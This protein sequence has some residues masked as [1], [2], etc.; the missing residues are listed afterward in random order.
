MRVGGVDGVPGGWVVCVLSGS[1]RT[2]RVSWSVVPDA[3]AVLELG[4]GCDAVGVDIPLVLPAGGV[5]RPAEVEAAARLGTARSSLFPTPPEQVL[6]A[7]SYP[8]ACA[9]AQRV[10]GR[11]ISVQTW[12]IV[13]KIRE[14]QRVE[15][16]G[17]VVEAH[18]ELSF[19]TM[20][21]A[22]G[23]A[24][25]K[26]ARGAGQRIAALAGW[27]DPARLLGDLPGAA[28]LDDVLDALACA[29]TAERV[30]RGTAEFLGG[31]GRGAIAI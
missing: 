8:D 27:I 21:P 19:R 16:P 31:P 15:L 2:R 24:S 7:D 29:W 3:A 23:F 4:T 25:K 13:P 17:S 20:A 5:R 9:A 18:P 28:R 10:T 22:V 30:A 11:K 12:N 1:G 26:T 6:A 14:F